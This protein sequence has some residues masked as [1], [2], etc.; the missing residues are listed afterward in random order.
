[1]ISVIVP[2][3]NSEKYLRNTLDSIIA[4]NFDNYELLLINDGSTDSSLDICYEYKERYPHVK[5]FSQPN[6]GLPGAR[7]TGILNSKGDYLCFIDS[8]DTVEKTY[9]YDLYE[10]I[11]KNNLDWVECATNVYYGKELVIQRYFNKDIIL[12]D[13]KKIKDHIFY[14]PYENITMFS[15]TSWASIFKKASLNG[16]LFNENITYSEDTIFNYNVV[17]NIKSYGFLN[18][19][20]YN[21]MTD[22]SVITGKYRDNFIEE[23][24]TLI[25]ELENIRRENNDDITSPY[26]VFLFNAYLSVFSKHIFPN[27]KL[28]IRKLKYEKLDKMFDTNP[29]RELVSKIKPNI[30]DVLSYRILI[31]L[32]IHHKYETLYWLWRI[33]H[34]L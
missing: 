8:D 22:N 3:Y 25:V 20:L 23:I 34:L 18:K 24:N 19:A 12:K 11:T 27:N 32:F 29:H 17:H 26:C 4:N 9:L 13:F 6:K 7:N 2:I 30:C 14:T 10:Y 28:S 21:Y 1:M 33:K 15:T 5:V 16:L 31:F